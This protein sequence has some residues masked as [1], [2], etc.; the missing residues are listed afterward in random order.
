MLQIAFDIVEDFLF[1]LHDHPDVVE[2]KTVTTLVHYR[3]KNKGFTNDDIAYV[4]RHSREKIESYQFK[5][6]NVDK[7]KLV[8]FLYL[9]KLKMY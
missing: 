1:N 2:F 4:K 7:Q 5:F 6:A 9:S 8:F 3:M